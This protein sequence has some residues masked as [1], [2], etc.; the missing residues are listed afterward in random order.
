MT[1][2]RKFKAVSVVSICA[3]VAFTVLAAQGA[4]KKRAK[5]IPTGSNA[6]FTLDSMTFYGNFDN[7]PPGCAIA[8]P[9]IHN[10]NGGCAG[11]T[12]TFK[13]PI[14]FAVAPQVQNKVH[15]GEIIYIPSLQK[16]FV[17]EDDCTSS[18]PGGVAVQ[19]QGCDGELKAGINEFDIWIGATSAG[20]NPG[21]NASNNQMTS[22]EDRLTASNVKIILNATSGQ[23]VNTAPL[24]NHGKCIK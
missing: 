14:T 5:T 10:Q 21:G 23:P 4:A 15:A 3:I 22:C 20:D 12:G 19:G 6:S 1:P 16:Y 7:S 18:G 9:V 8:H 17:M 13:D 2:I 11:G 24:L